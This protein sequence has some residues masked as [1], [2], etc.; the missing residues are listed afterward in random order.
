MVTSSQ[1]SE[2]D[3]DSALIPSVILPHK[4]AIYDGKI[5][6]FHAWRKVTT[7]CYFALCVEHAKDVNM[8]VCTAWS[9]SPLTGCAK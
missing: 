7:F 3:N 4:G 9:S 1:E 5:L 8:C 2:Q 6:S